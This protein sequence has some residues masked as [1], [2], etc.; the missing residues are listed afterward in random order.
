MRVS[1]HNAVAAEQGD[2]RMGACAEPVG[3]GVPRGDVVHGRPGVAGFRGNE[4]GPC[5]QLLANALRVRARQLRAH[6]RVHNNNSDD[7]Q[8]ERYQKQLGADPK[9]QVLASS[10][11][12]TKR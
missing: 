6:V 5:E 4:P 3:Q 12:A 7:Y 10:A 8:P 2:M 9:R 1:K 11:V